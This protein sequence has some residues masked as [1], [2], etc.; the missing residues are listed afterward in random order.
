MSGSDNTSSILKPGGSQ[1]FL[2]S[3]SGASATTG[4]FFEKSGSLIGA[5]RP[6]PGWAP[7]A[8]GE[9]CGDGAAPCAEGASGGAWVDRRATVVTSSRNAVLA[10]G[11]NRLISFPV[12]R[13]TSGGR[14]CDGYLKSST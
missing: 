5:P 10:I 13:T 12:R 9:P 7:G 4:A 14:V 3:S 8:R 2:R 1:N 11:T 6:P